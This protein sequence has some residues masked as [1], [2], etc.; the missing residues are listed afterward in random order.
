M[1]DALLSSLRQAHPRPPSSK[2]WFHFAE[3]LTAKMIV[4][5]ACS[6]HQIKSDEFFDGKKRHKKVVACR[7]D[8]I[9][10][11]LAAGYSM[12]DASRA[13]GRHYDTIRHWAVPER[14]TK[15]LAWVKRRKTRPETQGATA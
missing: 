4:R 1:T 5:T 11:L 15:R 14:R 8:A 9:T 13:M 6:D 3:P 10:Q 2:F 7:L 12:A